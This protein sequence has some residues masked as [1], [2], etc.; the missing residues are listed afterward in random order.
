MNHVDSCHGY[1][2]GPLTTYTKDILRISDHVLILNYESLAMGYPKHH[3]LDTTRSPQ[4]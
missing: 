2:C 4:R 1:V 3:R